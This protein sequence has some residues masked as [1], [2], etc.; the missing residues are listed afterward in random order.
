MKAYEH[1]T[2][3]V[4]PPRTYTFIRV[5]GRAFHT[6]TKGLKRP[7][8]V[9][10]ANN[11]DA[12]AAYLAEHISGTV[13][14]YVQSDEITL[15]LADFNSFSTQAWFGGQVQK[16]VSV[17]AGTATAAFNFFNVHLYNEHNVISMA[18]FDARVFTIPDRAEVLNNFIWRQRDCVKNSISMAAQS[19]FSHRELL[20]LNGNDLQEKLFTERG[21]NWNDYPDGFKRGR[22]VTRKSFMETVEFER[23]D[24][25]G[26]Q[27]E[28]VERHRWV[29][30]PAPH[31][32]H[33]DDG[34][35][36]AI[37]PTL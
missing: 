14:A 7:F 4:L 18:H 32:T 15:L 19:E 12:T 30:E 23:R 20:G 28:E 22:V 34:L 13:L 10:F 36:Q 24:K 11:M 6:Y 3:Q 21:V 1:V 8:D 25:P 31:F 9:D 33:M 17:A 37:I 29:V 27:S 5:D 16:M 26:I 2:R 35:L